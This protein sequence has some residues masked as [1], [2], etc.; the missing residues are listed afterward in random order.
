MS[1]R[2]FVWRDG[3]FYELGI[4]IVPAKGAPTH[5]VIQ[6]SMPAT[7]HPCDGKTYD[8]KSEFRRVT[9]AHG[10]VELGNDLP[11]QDR[12]K[13][14]PV[15]DDIKRSLEILKSRPTEVPIERISDWAKERE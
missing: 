14:P 13:L 5:S 15:R 4:D 11:K 3:K 10:G 9:A 7:W 12:Q 2:T 8:S 6:D 1:R